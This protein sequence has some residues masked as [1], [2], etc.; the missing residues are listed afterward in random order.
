VAKKRKGKSQ[1]PR[2]P[3]GS[4]EFHVDENDLEEFQRQIDDPWFGQDFS[5]QKQEENLEKPT[6]KRVQEQ[7]M[8]VDLHGMTVEKAMAA[9]DRAIF[10]A[11]Q[12]QVTKLRVITG[13]GLHSGPGGPVLA[14]EIYQ[15]VAKYLNSSVKILDASPELL[16]GV[17]LK[18]YFDVKIG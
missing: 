14:V 8:Q 16:S 12:R 10:Q 9:V 5:K 17:A 11:K 6:R 3:F 4:I 1:V 2:L 13:R 18:G 15:Y 7:T